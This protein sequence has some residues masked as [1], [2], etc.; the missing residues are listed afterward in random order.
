MHFSS[1]LQVPPSATASPAQR[2]NVEVPDISNLGIHDVFEQAKE[3]HLRGRPDVFEPDDSS[4]QKKAAYVVFCGRKTGIFETWPAAAQ[5]VHDLPGGKKGWFQ[6]YYR[7]DA[8]VKAWE[9]ALANNLVKDVDDT[10]HASPHVSTRLH[11]S[12][13]PT[14]HQEPPP[15][16]TE[17]VAWHDH[18]AER[19][20]P[21]SP[22]RRNHFAERHHPSSPRRRNGPTIHQE[23]P[24]ILTEYVARHD[25]LAKRDPPPSPSC[26]NHFA[27]RNR[28]SSPRRRNAPTSAKR[29]QVEV[30][31]DDEDSY[32][33]DESL[34]KHH[35]KL[36]PKRSAPPSASFSAESPNACDK[37]A[38]PPSAS[39][40][41]R[42]NPTSSPLPPLLPAPLRAKTGPSLAALSSQ[43]EMT[44]EECYWVVERG[45]TPGV[46]EG[47]FVPLPVFSFPVN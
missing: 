14:T 27:E 45:T 9:H 35:P 19:D 21:P 22:S 20:P 23:P 39:A 31:S 37:A 18:L 17:Y 42:P 10:P 3:E 34:P 12:P 11:Q 28:P 16:L 29:R 32:L 44:D 43:T 36:L 47:R 24:P 40:R 2:R 46:Y 38:N 25:H 8:A 5:Q 15:V 26:R 6:G 4:L 30:L 41:R 7:Y 13:V 33:S 1:A